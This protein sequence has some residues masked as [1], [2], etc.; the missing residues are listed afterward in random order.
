MTLDEVKRALAKT[1]KMLWT[2]EDVTNIMKICQQESMM[3]IQQAVAKCK[4]KFYAENQRISTSIRSTIQAQRGFNPT[5]LS[6]IEIDL[7][8]L[9]RPFLL[10]EC[11]PS[12]Y[13]TMCPEIIA[14]P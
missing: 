9:D 4:Q 8:Q 6:T 2:A 3:K 12:P 7:S 1:P 10:E 11:D 14:S 5:L 13:N